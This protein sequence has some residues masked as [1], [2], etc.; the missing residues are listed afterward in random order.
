MYTYTNIYEVWIFKISII[1]FARSVL[2]EQEEFV[3]YMPQFRG[4]PGPRSGTGWVG[5]WVGEDMGD[6]WDSTGNVNEINT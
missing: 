6:F 5:E 4:M 1:I 2:Y 3:L